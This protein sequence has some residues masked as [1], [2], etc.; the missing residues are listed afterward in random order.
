MTA[1]GALFFVAARPF[2]HLFTFGS[3]GRRSR[4]EA[5]FG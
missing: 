3:Y 4:G 5:I 1:M 2:A